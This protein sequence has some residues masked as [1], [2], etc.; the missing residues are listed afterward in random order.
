[1]KILTHTIA[2]I[3]LFLLNVEV[4]AQNIDSI[5]SLADNAFMNGKYEKALVEYEK[6]ISLG[7]SDSTTM[8]TV[9]SYAAI[10]CQNLGMNEKS[11]EYYKEALLRQAPQLMVYDQ[12]IGLAKEQDDKELYEFALLKKKE[13]FPDFKFEVDQSLSFLYYRTKQYNKLHEVIVPLTEMFPENL[14]FHLF[15]ATAKQNIGDIEGAMNSYQKTLELDPDNAGANM[16][17]GMIL[18][19]RA[20]VKYEEVKENYNNISN[21]SRVDY[22]DYRNNLEKPKAMYREALV[23]LL[24]AYEN[25]A[26]AGLKG[27]IKNAYTRLEE[28]EKAEQY[29]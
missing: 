20:S 9:Y 2:V 23:Y 5:N 14:R 15:A 8:A 12:M 29:N 11:L 6:I 4:F 16:G 19:N 17:V 1:M 18:Y 25:K 13:E 7:N 21:P 10:S 3:A 26:Y 27:I 24:K 28:K 22:S